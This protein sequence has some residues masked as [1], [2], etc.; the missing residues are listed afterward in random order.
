MSVSDLADL[1]ILLNDKQVHNL[2]FVTGT[3]FAPHLFEALGQ[4]RGRGIDLPV[5][6]NSS[7]YETVELLQVLEGM[8]DIYLPDIRYADN[9]VALQ[10]SKVRD[11]VEVDRAALM[12]MYRQVGPLALDA[13]DIAVSGMI[14]RHLVL[15]G[16]LAGTRPSLT[17]LRDHIGNDVFVSL[18]CQYFPAHQAH[19][20]PGLD[21]RLTD[22]E[23]RSAIDILEELGF[24]NAWAQDPYEP[25]CA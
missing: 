14:V 16:G 4:A 15:P 10:L 20:L 22:E 11:Y 21:R 5:V 7:G 1:Y 3:H 25:G 6:W 18:M 2:N 23:Y 12:E 24:E 13:D 17:W 8:V 19:L 9:A